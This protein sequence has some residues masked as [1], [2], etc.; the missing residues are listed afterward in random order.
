MPSLSSPKR[1][2]ARGASNPEPLVQPHAGGRRHHKAYLSRWSTVSLQALSTA[3]EL[4]ESSGTTLLVLLKIADYASSDGFAYPSERRLAESARCDVRSVRRAVATLQDLREIEVWEWVDNKNVRH[5]GFRF[6]L[7][8]FSIYE[9]LRPGD[10]LPGRAKSTYDKKLPKG[11]REQVFR[12]DGLTCVYCQSVTDVGVDH[13][14]PRSRG[15]SDELDNLCCACGPCNA[16]KGNKML[17]EWMG[18]NGQREDILSPRRQDNLSPTQDDQQ[19][20]M[21]SPDR[22]LVSYPART[23]P[24][25]LEP[26]PSNKPSRTNKKIEVGV[27]PK[28][29]VISP[30]TVNKAVVTR[31]EGNLSAEILG[32]WNEITGQSLSSK[33]WLT[34]II[35]RIREKP[36]LSVEDHAFII[37]ANCDDPWWT[38]DPNPSVI[39][40]NGAQFERSMIKA[41]SG[42]KNGSAGAFEIA[43]A[44]IEQ[45]ER[46]KA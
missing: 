29:G 9:G 19:D 41:A 11:L 28:I 32:R 1:R 20:K 5:N 15:G 46:S 39:Y 36:E 3:W 21:S 38:G 43:M 27:I 8:E 10:R 45:I 17:D 44:A 7:G 18:R 25:R 23:V 24:S 4:S 22:T 31:D 26:S 33:E 2:A 12:R 16:S 34:K 37:K 13:I 35:L 40:G 14:V 6:L 42:R 30:A